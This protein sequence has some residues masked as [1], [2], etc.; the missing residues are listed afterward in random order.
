M[1]LAFVSL[2]SFAFP[3][4]CG[5][6]K[7]EKSKAWFK[8][9]DVNEDPFCALRVVIINEIGGSATGCTSTFSQRKERK[10]LL[11]KKKDNRSVG[12]KK[13]QKR[14]NRETKKQG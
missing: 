9:L 1:L 14:V 7:K 12:P 6:K 8:S 11:K 13:K 5:K 2:E 10:K 3:F 4:S